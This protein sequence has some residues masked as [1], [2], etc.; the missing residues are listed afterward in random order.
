MKCS[1]TIRPNHLGNIFQWAWTSVGLDVIQWAWTTF[2]SF[3]LLE[4]S[5]GAYSFRSFW[6]G[7]QVVSFHHKSTAE[8]A[9]KLSNGRPSMFEK[10][11]YRQ[12]CWHLPRNWRTCE[13]SEDQSAWQDLPK[14][15]SQTCNYSE[16][17]QRL[18]L[19]GS[20]FWRD[21][22]VSFPVYSLV[23]VFPTI[24]L[25]SP[26]ILSSVPHPSDSEHALNSAMP[27]DRISFPSFSGCINSS[28]VKLFYNI[29]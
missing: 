8:S 7:L 5:H 10:V 13:G 24:T 22:Y 2:T 23:C 1:G 28:L 11:A 16:K 21:Y 19:G 26:Y 9:V 17:P 25:Q 14:T 3:L 6:L 20:M 18:L 12:S 4:L 27:C 29:Y 15:R